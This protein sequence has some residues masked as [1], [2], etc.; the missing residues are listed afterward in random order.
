[1]AESIQLYNTHHCSNNHA[2]AP[3]GHQSH[4]SQPPQSP[5]VVPHRGPVDG[6]IANH[7][8]VGTREVVAEHAVDACCHK[9]AQRGPL[10]SGR[11][12]PDH[13]PHQAQQQGNHSETPRRPRNQYYNIQKN[14]NYR[15]DSICG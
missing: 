13:Q 2:S 12:S 15:H 1:M 5:V 3:G 6:A 4:L 9:D 10:N 7:P 11:L 8:H 14:P